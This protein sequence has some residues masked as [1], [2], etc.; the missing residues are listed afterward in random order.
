MSNSSSYLE[1][2]FGLGGKR[3]IVTGA[4]RG[5]GQA[6]ALALAESGASI[7]LIQVSFTAPRRRACAPK[8]AQ[9]RQVADPPHP[10]PHVR[11]RSAPARTWRRTTKSRRWDARSTSWCATSPSRRT[12]RAS[13][14]RSPARSRRADLD[15]TSI[16]SST[17]EA[18]SAGGCSP[19]SVG[20]TH[21]PS[22]C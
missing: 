5:I 7:V 16:F 9:P 19:Y 3:A 20:L 8:C 15:S 21:S 1:K 10:P 22:S 4:T 6:M 17:V 2:L 13:P 12:S 14:R 18:S 11:L